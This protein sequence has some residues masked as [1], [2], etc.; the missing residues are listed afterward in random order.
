MKTNTMR[1]LSVIVCLFVSM[2]LS[3]Q[4]GAGKIVGKWAFSAPEAPYDYRQGSC[5][6]KEKDGKLTATAT[7]RGSEL[8]ISDIKKEGDAYIC[9]FYL[10]GAPVKLT[11][12]ASSNVALEGMADSQ[13]MNIAVH[14]SKK[15]SKEKKDK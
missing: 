2:L 3:A 15:E 9:S 8:T 6:F 1:V 7:V 10:D 12:K 5:H 11:V 14:F 13:G 4:E